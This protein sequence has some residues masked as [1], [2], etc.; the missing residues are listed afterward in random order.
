MANHKMHPVMFA[1]PQLEKRA[2]MFNYLEILGS[3]NLP[4]KADLSHLSPTALDGGCHLQKRQWQTLVWA[5]QPR[6]K[7]NVDLRPF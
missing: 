4:I 1:K 6:L 3:Q 2:I 5:V 7:T